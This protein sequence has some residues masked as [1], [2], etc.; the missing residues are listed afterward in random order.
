MTT[1][2]VSPKGSVGLNSTMR[3]PAWW[4]GVWPGGT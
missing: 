4:I 3:A 1:P 2:M